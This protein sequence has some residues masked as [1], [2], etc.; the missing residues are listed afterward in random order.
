[1]VMEKIDDTDSGLIT[2]KEFKNALVKV[3]KENK[4]NLDDQ[5]LEE[6]VS[7]SFL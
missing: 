7:S 6:I 5:S 3:A 2:Q 4:I 1:M